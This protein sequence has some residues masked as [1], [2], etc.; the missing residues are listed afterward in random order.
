M[1]LTRT[2]TWK[3][4]Q[5]KNDAPLTGQV[6]FLLGPA[7][8]SGGGVTYVRDEHTVILDSAGV[9]TATLPRTDDPALGPE[10]DWV[11]EVVPELH[12]SAGN[13]VRAAFPF[14]ITVPAGTGALD[15][16]PQVPQVNAGGKPTVFVEGKQG[17]KGDTGATGPQGPQGLPGTNAVPSD[18]AV[19]GYINT[20]GTSETKTALLATIV[21]SAGVVTVDLSATDGAANAAAIRNAITA[22]GSKVVRIPAGSW[23]VS[24][25]VLVDRGVIVRGEGAASTEL[26]IPTFDVP[27]F[28]AL[29]A[30][31]PPVFEDLH[32]R[33]SAAK[34][35]VTGSVRGGSAT[36]FA[37]GIWTN[38]SGTRVRRVK[39]TGFS[40]GVLVVN[41]NTAGAARTGHVTDV[42]VEDLESVG[43]D[44][45][46]LAAGFRRLGIHRP[47]GTYALR[48]GSADPAHLV[49]VSEHSQAGQV[50]EDLVLMGGDAWDGTGGHAYQV[51]GVSGVK[52]RD[53]K[54]RRCEGL[55]SYATLA[56]ADV[57]GLQ[58]LADK[59]TANYSLYG[60]TGNKNVNLDDVLLDMTTDVAAARVE[61]VGGRVTRFKARTVH[62]AY[63]DTVDLNVYGDAL[64]LDG[65]EFEQT[66]A[67][68][69]RGVGIQAGKHTVRNVSANQVR[70]GVTV[71]AGA[72]DG[73]VV[74]VDP[75][76]ITAP[77]ATGRV[78]STSA[79]PSTIVRLR[80]RRTSV[81]VGASG[82]NV[83]TR[84]DQYTTVEVN[85]TGTIGGSFINPVEPFTGAMVTYEVNNTAAGAWPVNG[86]GTTYK[87][88]SGGTITSFPVGRRSI[89]FTYNGTDWVEVA[90]T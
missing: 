61:S 89:T 3:V 24:G 27:V 66:G 79:K 62:A 87:F 45:G 59:I 7:M 57:Q 82:Q 60:Q 90:R 18:S 19:A 64:T 12:D 34:A 54:A 68:G 28:D 67:G 25:S 83:N 36:S 35:A 23:P 43:C 63:A 55:F 80:P 38:T 31:K 47:R 11:Y 85:A 56:D 32:V 73:N 10:S 77:E 52:I 88:G 14:T 39:A 1:A 71:Y 5:T 46:V 42:L 48:S 51:K 20:A 37:S 16:S 74:E 58:S 22:H 86:W 21:D 6:H 81:T 84:A 41:W 65:V 13:R 53:A 69:W 15:I 49:Y 78:V 75:G 76:R 50:N 72:S 70:A 40:A 44:W 4:L 8:V 33:T 29:D 30:T 2:V 17:P 26:V 9:A